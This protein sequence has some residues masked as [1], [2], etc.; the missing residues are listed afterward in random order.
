M[1]PLT[2]RF[3]STVNTTVLQVSGG[4][5]PQFIGRNC[6]YGGP[7]INSTGIFNYAEGQAPYP[8]A[9]QGSTVLK[10]KSS[11]SKEFRRSRIRWRWACR[12]FIRKCSGDHACGI[13]GTEAKLGREVELGALPAKD[14]ASPIASLGAGMAIWNCSS[15]G[16]GSNFDLGCGCSRKGAWPRAVLFCPALSGLPA[17]GPLPA[18]LPAAEE[19]SPSFLRGERVLHPSVC[20]ECHI[21][22]HYLSRSTL[23]RNQEP[24]F[25]LQPLWV[26]LWPRQLL[27]WNLDSTLPCAKWNSME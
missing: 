21:L 19:V 8:W 26:V 25:Q 20:H 18:T 10:V 5:N 24:A 14:L 9:V 13:E 4:L 1:G 11:S 27:I 12:A 17:E 15:W 2:R 6:L 7:T 3:F 22:H 23:T 16:Q